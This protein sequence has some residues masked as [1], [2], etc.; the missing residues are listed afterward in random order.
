MDGVTKALWAVDISEI[1]CTI[2]MQ[3]D[4]R[5]VRVSCSRERPVYLF[6]D[7]LGDASFVIPRTLKSLMIFF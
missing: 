5:R 7:L 3:D 1:L 2:V 6:S 4:G